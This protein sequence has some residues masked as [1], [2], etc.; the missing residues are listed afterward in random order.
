MGD[1]IPLHGREL[2][3]KNVRIPPGEYLIYHFTAKDSVRCTPEGDTLDGFNEVGYVFENLA[4][5]QQ[6]CRWK[7][8]RSPKLGCVY[9][10]RWKTIDQFTNARHMGQL[11]RAKSPRRQLVKG[12]VFSFREVYCSGWRRSVI[13]C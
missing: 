9:D 8:K 10:H 1:T 6:Y 4:E 2:P 3:G 7:V 13:G 5:A 11:R 12:I